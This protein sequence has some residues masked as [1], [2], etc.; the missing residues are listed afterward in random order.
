MVQRALHRA[1]R[2]PSPKHPALRSPTSPDRRDPKAVAATG[3]RLGYIRR[4]DDK[5]DVTLEIETL[6]RYGCT[7]I[8]VGKVCVI[9]LRG[10]RRSTIELANV[11]RMLRSGDTLVVPRLACL[12][13]SLPKLID[14]MHDLKTRDIGLESLA[15]HID[16]RMLGDLLLEVAA[17]MVEYKRIWLSEC[18]CK[19]LEIARARGRK[20]GRRAIYTES[21]LEPVK[22]ALKNRDLT[23][24]DVAK[25]AGV[26]KITLYRHIS[27]RRGA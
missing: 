10:K 9:G 15:E 14:I 21:S 7:E 16:T 25:A 13:G 8:H 2:M 20:V 23:L 17:F 27:L 3:V 6:K 26:S 18:T 1:I 4:S 11:L 5:Q 12:A 24:D 22:A 19:G